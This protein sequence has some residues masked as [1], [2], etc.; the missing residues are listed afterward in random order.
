MKGKI[1]MKRMLVLVVAVVTCI[2]SNTAFAKP[3]FFEEGV[4]ARKKLA[5]QPS[6]PVKTS[7]AQKKLDNILNWQFQGEDEALQFADDTE[8]NNYVLADKIILQGL[9]KV[10]AKTVVLESA[11]GEKVKFGNLEISPKLCWTSPEGEKPESIALMMVYENRQG[12][13]PKRIFRGWMF[14][15]SP[16]LSPI[17]HPVYDVT[18]VDCKKTRKEIEKVKK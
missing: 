10:T 16:A 11:I 15:S 3:G 1:K 9:N 8:Y 6:Q 5:E 17:D 18:L 4:N 2:A 14:S 7:E 12:E 13:K